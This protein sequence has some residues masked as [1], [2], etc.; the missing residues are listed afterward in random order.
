M[1][2]DNYIND[3]NKSYTQCVGRID[4]ITT[5]PYNE[6]QLIGTY[7]DEIRAFKKNYVGLI[8]IIPLNPSILRSMLVM[9]LYGEE[10]SEKK[11]IFKYYLDL[12]MKYYDDDIFSLTRNI[13]KIYDI[14][15]YFDYF[16]F[17]EYNQYIIQILNMCFKFSYDSRFDIFADN[18]YEVVGPFYYKNKLSVLYRFN[19][20]LEHPIEILYFGDTVFGCIDMFGH[21]DINFKTPTHI[22]LYNSEIVDDYV[23]FISLIVAKNVNEPPT[24]NMK[25]FIDSYLERYQYMKI[26]K[27]QYHPKNIVDKI[28]DR[29]ELIKKI[30]L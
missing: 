15:N 19:Y 12:L 24:V 16:Y 17:S 9:D 21:S 25:M 20:I 4:P 30:I 2:L 1:L 7:P 26:P 29:T 14:K 27:F 18:V 22:L 28:I 10:M 13:P 3:F 11:K 5:F 8:D 23:E 6:S